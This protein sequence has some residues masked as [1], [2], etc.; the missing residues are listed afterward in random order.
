L[1]NPPW[2]A[3]TGVANLVDALLNMEPL[4]N[5]RQK[6]MKRIARLQMLEKLLILTFIL[7]CALIY[8]LLV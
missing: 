4:N 6:E 2:W 3:I 7:V 1:Y 5:N 8:Y